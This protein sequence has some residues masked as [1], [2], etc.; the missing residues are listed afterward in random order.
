[1]RP[2]LIVFA[3]LLVTPAFAQDVDLDKLLEQETKKE[4]KK[5]PEVV[6]ATFK[7]TRISNGHSVETLPAG[8]LDFKIQHRFGT[9]N[10]GLKEFFGMDQAFIRLGLDYGITDRLMI[11]AGR[12]SYQKQL[13]A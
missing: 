7:T 8:V 4:T 9:L 11:G 5:G 3:V 1:M 13:D 2:L 10:S 12:A 6:L